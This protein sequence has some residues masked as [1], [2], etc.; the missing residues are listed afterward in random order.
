MVIAVIPSGVVPTMLTVW[1]VSQKTRKSLVRTPSTP[2]PIFG[3]IPTSGACGSCGK[4]AVRLNELPPSLSYP[5]ESPAELPR[6]R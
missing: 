1:P 3:G 6:F 4:S 2:N 5:H